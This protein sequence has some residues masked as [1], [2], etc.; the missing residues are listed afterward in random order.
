MVLQACQS[1]EDQEWFDP[2]ASWR[3]KT[4]TTIEVCVQAEVRA[5]RYACGKQSSVKAGEFAKMDS[6]SWSCVYLRMCV[7]SDMCCG[8]AMVRR[9]SIEMAAVNGSV[10]VLSW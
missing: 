10:A 7:V 4:R 6:V 8:A 1:I 9:M 5:F 2:C 3:S